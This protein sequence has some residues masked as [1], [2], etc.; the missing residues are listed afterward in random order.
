MLT[1]MATHSNKKDDAS[2]IDMRD[3]SGQ[4]AHALLHYLLTRAGSLGRRKSLVNEFILTIWSLR[5]RKLFTSLFLT[6]YVC[7]V[8]SENSKKKVF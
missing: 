4:F 8:S 6:M 5:A 1:D 3:Q 7:L 2:E